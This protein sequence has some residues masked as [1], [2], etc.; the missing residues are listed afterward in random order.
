MA[1]INTDKNT[2]NII[3]IITCSACGGLGIAI[4]HRSESRSQPC[5]ECG[6]AGVWLVKG[7]EKYFWQPEGKA[8]SAALRR[9]ELAMVIAIKVLAIFFIAFSYYKAVILLESS[10]NVFALFIQR[11]PAPFLFW[12]STVILIYWIYSRRMAAK[13]E[14]EKDFDIFKIVLGAFHKAETKRGNGFNIDSLLDSSAKRKICEAGEIAKEL[15]SQVNI[16]HLLKALLEDQD[17]E[18]IIIRLEV[19]QKEIIKLIN[20]KIKETATPVLGVE[21]VQFDANIKKA[22]NG[23]EKY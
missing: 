14:R 20:N 6:G 16:W 9:L 15:K 17:I 23:E 1:E 5:H 22:K 10:G 19:S 3:G 8:V 21:K 13:K 12:V 18:R 4:V 11:G 2:E 7:N